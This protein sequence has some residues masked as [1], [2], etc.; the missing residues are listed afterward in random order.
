[1]GRG[2]KNRCPGDAACRREIRAVRWLRRWRSEE[3]E[4]GEEL[5]AHFAIEVKQRVE[6]GEKLEEAE[7]GARRQFGNIGLVKEVTRS[8]WGHAWAGIFCSR[9]EICGE[10]NAQDAPHS[11]RSRSL[12]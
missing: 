11:P 9:S 7:S 5:R 10:N 3:N 2:S 4:L 12:R 1:M 6:A 8:M